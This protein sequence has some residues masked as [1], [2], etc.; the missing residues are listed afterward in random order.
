MPSSISS[1]SDIAWAAGLFE[2]EG[3]WTEAK[4]HWSKYHYRYPR[5]CL[6]TT[7]YDVL[8]RFRAIVGFGN[9]HQP[10]VTSGGKKWWRWYATSVGQTEQLY[11]LFLPWLGER[12]RVRAAQILL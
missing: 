7:D 5:A 3:S 11:K 10:Q 4:S 8:K 6:G 9:I 1:E 12:R 2:G